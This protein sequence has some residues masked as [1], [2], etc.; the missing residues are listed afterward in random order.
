MWIWLDVF[1]HLHTHDTF[2]IFTL[3][4]L[5]PNGSDTIHYQYNVQNDRLQIPDVA[6]E[7][8]EIQNDSARYMN[9]I[10]Y[11]GKWD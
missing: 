10:Q 5:L 1:Y 6:T 4:F 2:L 7:Q 9:V 3:T 8:I 11:T